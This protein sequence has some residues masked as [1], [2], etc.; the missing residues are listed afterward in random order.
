MKLW[1]DGMPDRGAEE[2]GPMPVCVV[3]GKRV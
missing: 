2:A 1:N 3:V